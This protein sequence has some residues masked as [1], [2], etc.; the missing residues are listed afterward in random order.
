M[1]RTITLTMSL[2]SAALFLGACHKDPTSSYIPNVVNL[3]DNF[4]FRMSDVRNH[5]TVMVYYWQME[6]TSANI[7]QSASI[8]AGYVSITVE[9][10][11][12]VQV[13]Q[14]DMRQSGGFSTAS[15]SPGMWRIR[16]SLTDFSGLLD[17]RAQRR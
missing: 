15:G 10:D 14:T 8:Q 9:D 6:G 3:R 7:D 13:Y 5:D 1:T 12:R 11:S 4:H 16:I 17:F 2:A